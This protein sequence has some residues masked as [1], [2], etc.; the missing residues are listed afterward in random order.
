MA[1]QVE[2]EGRV[3]EVPDDA[4]DDEVAT[5]LSASPAPAPAPAPVAD[6]SV[7]NTARTRLAR[8]GLTP[9]LLKQSDYED[10][11]FEYKP[12]T[13]DGGYLSSLGRDLNPKN[14]LASQAERGLNWVL[15]MMDP[16]G[17]PDSLPPDER[18]NRGLDMTDLG[19][20]DLPGIYQEASRRGE[21]GES[22]AGM[23]GSATAQ[24]LL[25]GGGFAA[26][27]L[28]RSA[29]T[30][31]AA[32]EAQYTEATGAYVPTFGPRPIA[33][34]M[35]DRGIV[36][37][38]N[39]AKQAAGLR[40]RTTA[41]NAERLAIPG[42]RSVRGA[43][44]RF[45]PSTDPMAVS[46]AARRATLRA[47][48][49]METNIAKILEALPETRSVGGA[50]GKGVSGWFNRRLTVG[51]VA[52]LGSMSAARLLWSV[53]RELVKTNQWRTA[54]PI[55]KTRFANALMVGDANLAAAT[56]ALIA[57]GQAG[58]PEAANTTADTPR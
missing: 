12:R 42:T 48:A 11:G 2:F 44:G 35:L 43:G 49:E 40:A 34:V 55:Y 18:S 57:S 19:A 39:P 45:E 10:P 31:A 4:T 7:A 54:L 32:A 9:E 52:S 33:R 24:S 8:R 46:N 20:P 41:L 16:T 53:S 1:R 28:I 22:L 14:I 58:D 50:V 13:T 30:R 5:I 23:Y 51:D 17:G 56:G 15:S 6:R 29:P 38:P 3:I 21:Q 37:A 26:G 36:V 47:Q 27:R 25:A